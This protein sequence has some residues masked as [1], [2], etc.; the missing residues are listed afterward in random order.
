VT[1][2]MS[3][4]EVPEEFLNLI[5][6]ELLPCHCGPLASATTRPPRTGSFT[7]AHLD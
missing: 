1:T 5:E 6:L 3:P 4:G 2:S 7:T